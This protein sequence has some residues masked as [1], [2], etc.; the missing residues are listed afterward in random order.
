MVKSQSSTMVCCHPAENHGC[1]TAGVTC[2]VFVPAAHGQPPCLLAGGPRWVGL[3]QSVRR[4]SK[5]WLGVIKKRLCPYSCLLMLS[6]DVG[7]WL[8]YFCWL[9]LM[10]QAP[11]PRVIGKQSQSP[12]CIRLKAFKALSN[13]KHWR[14]KDVFFTHLTT[15][16]DLWLFCGGF[17]FFFLA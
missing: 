3:G 12:D 9:I 6:V 14:A 8:M 1:N 5:A 16:Q 2:L 13:L 17:P 7:C 15:I 10:L 11:P 4:V